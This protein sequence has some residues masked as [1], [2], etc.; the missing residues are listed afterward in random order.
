MLNQ[1]GVFIIFHLL[2]ATQLIV[3]EIITIPLLIVLTNILILDLL[4]PSDRLEQDQMVHQLTMHP[5]AAELVPLEAAEE[6]PLYVRSPE[7]VENR[8]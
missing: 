8:S 6:V 7:E 5:A 4:L 2:P 1:Q 3:V